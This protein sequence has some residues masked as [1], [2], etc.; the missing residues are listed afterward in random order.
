MS[1]HRSDDTLRQIDELCNRFEAAWKAFVADEIE[2][3]EIE[4][5]LQPT[6]ADQGKL[7]EELLHLELTKRRQ[8]GEEPQVAEYQQRFPEQGELVQQVFDRSENAPAD[9]QLIE[10]FQAAETLTGQIGPYKILQEIGEGGMGTVYMAEQTSPVRRRVAL[11]VIKAGLDTKQVVAR[12]EAERQALAMM[13]HQNIAKVLDVGV[14]DDGRPYFAMELV[15]G[16]PIT[17]YCDKNRLPLKDR[18]ELF[19][20]VCRAI[21]HAHQKGVIHRDLKPSNVL[22]TL[23]DSL[24]VA[25]VIDFG[26]AKALQSQLRLTDKTLF[27]EFGQVVGTL[28]YMSPE[29]AEMN[30]LSV[31][32]RTDVYS[33]GVMLYELLTGSTPLD[34]E[35]IRSEAFH[36]VL[37]LIREEEAPRPSARL[38]DSGEAISGISEQRQIDPRRLS[39]ILKGELDWI[40][41]KAL[42]KDRA[43]R[44][45]G[46]G[47]LADDVQ[48]YL[49]HEAIEARPPSVSYRLQKTI[50][51]HKGAF[52]T[53]TAIVLL[54]V[55]GLVGTGSMWLRAEAETARARQAEKE[56]AEEAEKAR[57][58]E[59]TAKREAADQYVAQGLAV[60]DSGDISGG[61][62]LC[63]RAFELESDRLERESIHRMRIASLLGKCA[64]SQHVWAHPGI[65][66]WAIQLSEDGT[67]VITC[68]GG[69]DGETNRG[70]ARVWDRSTGEPVTPWMLHAAAVLWA[71]FSSD[72]HRVVTASDDGT[73]RVW[74]SATGQPQGI[75]LQHGDSV[76]RAVFSP[77]S[78][79]LATACADGWAR[80]FETK[81]LRERFRVK[82]QNAVYRV[83]FNRDGSMLV[84]TSRDGTARVWSTDNGS[85]LLDPLMHQDRVIDAVFSPDGRSLVTCGYDA[86]A[87]LWDV[88]SGKLLQEFRGHSDVVRH[89]AFSPDGQLLS[90]AG[91]DD[92]AIVWDV[93]TGAKTGSPLQHGGEV[94]RVEFSPDG[95]HLLTA[96]YDNTV[97][98]WDVENL[99]ASP[100]QLWHAGWAVA[101]Q[102]AGSSS[103]ILTAA[104]DGTARLWKLPTVEQPIV[105]VRH[106]G[107]VNSVR[108]SPD[109]KRIVSGSADNTLKVWDAETGQEMLTLKGHTGPVNSVAFSPDDL[110][111]ASGDLKGQVKVWNAHN[112]KLRSTLQCMFPV[113]DLHFSPDGSLLVVA[114]GSNGQGGRVSLLETPSERPARDIVVSPNL[115]RSARFSADGTQIIVLGEKGESIQVR[116]VRTG[117]QISQLPPLG[118]THLAVFSPD[119]KFILTAAGSSLVLSHRR[120][121]APIWTQSG[122]QYTIP[123]AEFSPDG[124]RIVS[125]SHDDTARIW[126]VSTSQPLTMAIRHGADVNRARFSPNGLLIATGSSDQTVGIWDAA[127]GRRVAGPLPHPFWVTD[128]RFSPDGTVLA[129][130]GVHAR[131]SNSHNQVWMW[132]LP[133]E[134]RPIPVLSRTA[135][136]IASRAVHATGGLVRRPPIKLVSP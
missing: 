119:S 103:E 18:L 121:G 49:D 104:R 55:A 40:A 130:I 91:D 28:E 2:R 9:S 135:Q 25:K 39:L 4:Q 19:G 70:F 107:G 56:K 26:L 90:T 84:T 77:D 118:Q 58:A 133:S 87:K 96:S 29:Q 132:R 71:E 106:T 113:R 126:S 109:G 54:L 74:S 102:F 13:D 111:V 94:R 98:I 116:D 37:E 129:V 112:G 60:A 134:S 76:Y 20:Q 51:K 66:V 110:Y 127:S 86:L 52:A 125:A 105:V 93:H 38:S 75:T 64:T 115:I 136:E 43:R 48:R 123:H 53:G 128:V 122:H 81:T 61:L 72:G 42:E 3:P 120:D 1:D 88:H 131:T 78:T 67:R 34:R 14:T 16:I 32:T 69:I 63:V 22:V 79:L 5:Y 50:R 62:L 27:T 68:G 95:N 65:D 12:F 99:E 45:D 46:A 8:Q 73:V 83:V 85:A 97:K 57:L 41:V 17:K 117:R 11:K 15:Q 124:N 89:A 33:L 24:P 59:A 10:S 23:Y 108:F 7:L 36:R 114:S 44:Y 35:R 6:V 80:V 101:A 47:A 92:I 100:I 31:D 30:E 21:Q 82:H